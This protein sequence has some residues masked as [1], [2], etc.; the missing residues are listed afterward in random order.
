MNT[1]VLV[2]QLLKELNPIKESYSWIIH[3]LEELHGKDEVM[4]Y[5][6]IK[7]QQPYDVRDYNSINKFFTQFIYTI[8]HYVK[9]RQHF[10]V[11]TSQQVQ[12]ISALLDY[13]AT[14]ST[15]FNDALTIYKNSQTH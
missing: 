3:L 1:S 10:D 15:K 12:G 5:F 11:L 7:M 9:Q 8:N 2:T 14:E 6:L 4:E 13:L